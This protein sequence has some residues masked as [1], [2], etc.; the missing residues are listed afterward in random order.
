MKFVESLTPAEPVTLQEALKYGP[1]ARVRQRAHAIDLSSKGCKLSPLVAIFEGDR[2][3]LSGWLD[4]W[5]RQGLMGLYDAPR[6]GR[7][8]LYTEA[9]QQRLVELIEEQPQR[10]IEAQ[11]RLN[12]ETGKPASRRTLNRVLKKTATAGS[13]YDPH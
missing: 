2:A 13:G 3:T 11:A 10:L 7:P 1:S 9:E 12:Q 5:E 4:Q 8:P 6:A